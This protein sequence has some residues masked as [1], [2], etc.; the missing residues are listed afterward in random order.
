MKKTTRTFVPD[1]I[2]KYRRKRVAKLLAALAAVTMVSGWA[3]ESEAH[4]GSSGPRALQRDS[5]RH[6]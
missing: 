4:A 3:A 2:R 1:F 6:R 5:T